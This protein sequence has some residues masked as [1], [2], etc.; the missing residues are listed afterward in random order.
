MSLPGPI[1]EKMAFSA[2]PL[3]VYCG[4]PRFSLYSDTL[5]CTECGAERLSPELGYTPHE[6]EKGAHVGTVVPPIVL[7]Q[8]PKTVAVC[9]ALLAHAYPYAIAAAALQHMWLLGVPEDTAQDWGP[10]EVDLLDGAEMLWA[11]TWAN[12]DRSVTV[13]LPDRD[14]SDPLL[15]LTK[16]D[17]PNPPKLYRALALLDGV[18]GFGTW[19]RLHLAM[20]WLWKGEDA[21][22]TSPQAPA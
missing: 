21:F 6:R 12:E 13:A 7:E 1:P 8:R 16:H 4:S 3:C 19:S 2:L 11:F 15:I 22:P 17:A 10:F 20:R 9:V 18:G 14:D 5:H